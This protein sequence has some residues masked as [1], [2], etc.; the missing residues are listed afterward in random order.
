MAKV[1]G[2]EGKIADI[3]QQISLLTLQKPLLY[4]K[5]DHL[6]K[7]V[8]YSKTTNAIQVQSLTFY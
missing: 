5:L 1:R 3:A 8:I 7:T 2:K 4:Y 6:R